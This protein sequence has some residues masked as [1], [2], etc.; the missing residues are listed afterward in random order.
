MLRSNPVLTTEQAVSICGL[1]DD[2]HPD[3]VESNAP[4]RLTIE[5]PNLLSVDQLLLSVSCFCRHDSLTM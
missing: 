3:L 1:D 4:P 2:S 5:F